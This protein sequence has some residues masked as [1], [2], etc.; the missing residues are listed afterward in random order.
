MGDIE[1]AAVSVPIIAFF[2]NKGGVGDTSLVYHLAWMYSDL[3]VR[4][5]AADLDPRANLTAAFL[6]EEYLEDYWGKGRPTIGRC[7]DPLERGLGDIAE[8]ELER[9]SDNLGLL[10]GDLS[11]SGFEDQLSEAWPKC[12]DG[13]ER[14]FHVM[15]AFWRVMQRA[16]EQWRARFI[17]MDLGPNRGAINRAALIA[18]D[19]VAVPVSPDLFSLQGLQSLGPT[20]RQWRTEWAGRTSKNPDKSL[21]LPS[22][23]M[24]PVGYI[25]LPHSVRLDRPVKAYDKW[26]ARIPPTYRRYVLGQDAAAVVALADD[27]N[28]LSLLKHYQSLMPMAQEARKPMFHLKPADGAIGAHYDAAQRAYYDFRQL[29]SR[30][31]VRIGEPLPD[32]GTA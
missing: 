28:C 2:N 18:A 23:R 20:L 9:V 6:E 11:L 21:V 4:V 16:A 15:S 29:A 12:S 32:A 5:V 10:V 30:I 25:V 31:A 17:L 1:E 8:P 27:P 13:N 7:V 22:G 14:A 26:M 24:E 3:G 19:Y